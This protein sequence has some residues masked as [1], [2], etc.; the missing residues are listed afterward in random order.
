[1]NTCDTCK[2]W[3]PEEEVEHR[4]TCKTTGEECCNRYTEQSTCC[5][6]KI[7]ADFQGDNRPNIPPED[8]I[9]ASCDEGRGTLFVGPS[10][11]CIHHEPK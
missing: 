2:W 7:W 9:Y 3:T 10:F 11:G 6:P 4:F 8:G 1:M 5:H